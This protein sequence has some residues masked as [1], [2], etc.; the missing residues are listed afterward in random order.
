MA[1]QREHSYALLSVDTLVPYAQ[2]YIF[3]HAHVHVHPTPVPVRQHTNVHTLA[4]LLS[5]KLEVVIRGHSGL[6]PLEPVLVLLSL[7]CLG[8]GQGAAFGRHLHEVIPVIITPFSVQYIR[9]TDATYNIP[10]YQLLR[11]WSREHVTVRKETKI[12]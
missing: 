2:I 6:P 7:P 11:I 1:T 5:Y 10:T 4:H 12:H 9:A 3:T 8:W